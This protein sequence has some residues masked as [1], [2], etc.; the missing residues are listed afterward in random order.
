VIEEE[1]DR[2]NRM[3]ADL[4]DMSRLQSGSVRSTIELNAV[5]DLVG[6]VAQGV[7]GFLKERVL[8][9]DL[10]DGGTLLVGRF[11]FSASLRILVNLIE[12]AAK[13]SSAPAVIELRA[14]RVGEWIEITVADRGPGVPAEM[15]PQLFEPFVR[16]VNIP[17][18]VGGAGLGLAIARGLAEA[19][20]GTLTYTP[21]TGGGSVFTLRLPAADLPE[22]LP[23]A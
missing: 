13:Y 17:S 9:V 10:E 12:N 4:L 1:A 22:N 16:A 14:A 8:Q 2:L 19:Q 7:S 18:D 3:V 21:R 11:D 5:D 15:R 23:T 20:G 6:A